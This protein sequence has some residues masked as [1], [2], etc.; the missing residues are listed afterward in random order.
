MSLFASIFQ[1]GGHIEGQNQA[2]VI[3]KREDK[4]TRK[5]RKLSSGAQKLLKL[6]IVR[7]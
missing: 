1:D 3:D 4:L 5:L 7:L 6:N 2:L